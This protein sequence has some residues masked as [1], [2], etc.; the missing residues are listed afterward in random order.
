[1]PRL[2]WGPVDSAEYGVDRGVFYFPGGKAN[3][4]PG[5]V[6]VSELA[7]VTAPENRYYDGIKVE[8]LGN[9]SEFAAKLKCF[10]YPTSF[11]PCIG[12]VTVR[13]GF[14]LDEQPR[15]KFH[16]TYRHKV[17]QSHKLYLI[18]NVTASPTKISNNTL[19]KT[20]P[21]EP[22]EFDLTMV[23]ERGLS[24]ARPTALLMVDF[25]QVSASKR[26]ALEDI[27][28]GTTTVDGRMPSQ[29][30]VANLLKA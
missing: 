17:G 22:F 2:I 27:L 1:M 24:G 23:P 16:L 14:I 25:R 29:T 10:M 12:R 26:Q 21:N 20:T 18:Y 11:E 5:L 4:W 13:R 9:P 28:Y 15:Q 7:A 3:S 8:N 30:E 6:S 19:S